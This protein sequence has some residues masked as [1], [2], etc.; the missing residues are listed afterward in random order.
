MVDTYAEKVDMSAET[1]VYSDLVALGLRCVVGG[2]LDRLDASFRAM[3]SRSWSQDAHVEAE[4][5]YVLQMGAVL[6]EY[7]PRVRECLSRTYFNSMC[8]RL[9]TELLMK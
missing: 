4:S 5:A 1:D 8:T 3:Q 2:A 9:A 6:G 7:V